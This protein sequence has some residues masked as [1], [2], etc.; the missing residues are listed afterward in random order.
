MDDSF[1]AQALAVAEQAARRAGAVHR[2]LFGSDLAVLEY[3][4]YDTKLQADRDAEDAA[5]DCIRRAYPEHAILSEEA[6]HSGTRA[7]WSW[8]VDP[9]DGTLNFSRA[10]PH[11]CASVALRREREPVL[12]VIYDPVRDE[13]FAAVAG[14]GA[15]LNGRPIRVSRVD[16][17]EDAVVTAG[18][19]KDPATIR[20]GLAWMQQVLPLVRKVRMMGAAALDLAWVACGR[21]DA[22]MEAGVRTWDIA[23]GVV[24]VREAGGRVDTA[25]LPGRPEAHRLLAWNGRFP[26][27]PPLWELAPED[28]GAAGQARPA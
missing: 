17:A 6:G 16:R 12:G 21:L 10:I 23:A 8:V 5:L 1:L 27:P 2:R 4:Q 7:I 11:Y 24:I 25:P 3:S 19:M 14:R 22:Y 13:L 26:L 15:T 28:G 18:F 9:L 20:A